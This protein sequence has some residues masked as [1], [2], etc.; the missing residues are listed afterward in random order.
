MAPLGRQFDPVLR[1]GHPKGGLADTDCT[2]LGFSPEIS[3][4]LSSEDVRHSC[5][6]CDLSTVDVLCVRVYA[7]D[8]I[9]LVHQVACICSHIADS[10]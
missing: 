9:R 1:G 10:M 5:L 8:H 2:Y 6:T 4:I 3:C 7:A